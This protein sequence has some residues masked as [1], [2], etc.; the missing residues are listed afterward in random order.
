[1]PIAC[2]QSFPK[3]RRSRGV[4]PPSRPRHA[5]RKA[6][7]K[8]TRNRDPPGQ[9]ELSSAPFSPVWV[10]WAWRR[11]RNAFGRQPW[12]TWSRGGGGHGGV[13][14]KPREA[15]GLC[16]S[17]ATP[18]AP[19]GGCLR[20]RGGAFLVTFHPSMAAPL[21]PVKFWRPGKA[22]G[23]TLGRCSGLPLVMAQRLVS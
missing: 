12:V 20:R 11:G 6:T 17:W 10:T 7:R 19:P 2:Q 18:P 1:M 14:I 8:A 5:L 16:S 23:G 9:R 4:R 3:A 13:A 21:G 15:P 22:L